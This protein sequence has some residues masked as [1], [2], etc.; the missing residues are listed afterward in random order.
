MSSNASAGLA[1]LLLHVEAALLALNQFATETNDDVRRPLF[2][3]RNRYV[4]L[5]TSVIKAPFSSYGGPYSIDYLCSFNFASHSLFDRMQSNLSTTLDGLDDEDDDGTNDHR[6]RQGKVAVS[7]P[8]AYQLSDD[9][10]QTLNRII[11]TVNMLMFRIFSRVK[12]WDDAS[13]CRDAM[14]VLMELLG[15]G[16]KASVPL[17][18]LIQEKW[19][20]SESV[21]SYSHTL[22]SFIDLIKTRGK[23][24][25]YLQ[26]LV[27]LCSANGHAI[28]KIQEKLCELLFDTED[29]AA[30][31]IPTQPA[32]RG[33]EISIPAK[34]S[35]VRL[36]NLDVFYNEY[37]DSKRHT[38]LAPYYYGLLQLYCA[39]CMDRNY[40][41]IQRL[42]AIFPRANLLQTVQDAGLSRSMRAVLLNLL[43]VL[44]VDCEPQTV[45]PS[46][47]YTR[48]WKNAVV[49]VP[50]TALH[51]ADATFFGDL[52]IELLR[53]FKKHHGVIV[54]AEYPQNE[55][56]LAMVRTT[57]KLVAFGMFSSDLRHLV[58]LLVDL[59]D[60]R[61]DLVE[62]HRPTASTTPPE[63]S[64]PFFENSV[65]RQKHPAYR[66]YSV[67]D[68]E[69]QPMLPVQEPLSSRDV[70]T[71][72][73]GWQ[74][75]YT[76][77]KKEL[78]RFSA[79][80]AKSSSS[81]LRRLPDSKYTMSEWN[82][83]VMDIKE[84]I[85]T[86]LLCIDTFRLD[87]Q[88]S[89][90]LYTLHSTSKRSSTSPLTSSLWGSSGKRGT[91]LTSAMQN[92]SLE[93][94][95]SLHVLAGRRL[96]TVLLQALMYE[97][98]PLVS[99]ALELYMQ[100]FNQHDQL[101]K[102]LSSTLVIADD[103]TVQ[104]YAR[105]QAHVNDLRRLAETTE[106]WMDLTSDADF[107]TA[108]KACA[109]LRAILDAFNS[110][111][112]HR[113]V[114]HRI[115][116]N[117]QAIDH[118][119]AMVSA[120][121][122]FFQALFPSK[123][124]R[125]ASGC[126]PTQRYGSSMNVPETVLEEKQRNTLYAVYSH[127]TE[128]L[129]HICQHP[130][131]ASLMDTH[132]DTLLEFAEA[133][134]AA[135]DALCGLYLGGRT[136]A[137]PKT[138]V[139]WFVRW[140]VAYKPEGEARYLEFLR[141]L[142][143]RPRDRATILQQL[144]QY[145]SIYNDMSSGRHVKY[146]AAVLNLLAAC[147]PTAEAKDACRVEFLSLDQW[148]AVLEGGLATHEWALGLAC[149]RYFKDVILAQDDVF[150]G[151][152]ASLHL[153]ILQRV[154]ELTAKC[155]RLDL[156]ALQQV[157]LQLAAPT[158]TRYTL[159][160]IMLVLV[161]ALDA[162]LPR[163]MGI[164]KPSADEWRE[165]LAGWYIWLFGA[166]VPTDARSKDEL[167]SCLQYIEVL[168]AT[169]FLG[170][171]WCDVSERSER[172]RLDAGLG[173]LRSNAPFVLDLDSTAF[174]DLLVE[175][176]AYH[177][178]LKQ[179]P[180]PVT[181]AAA[182]PRRLS[183]SH[184]PWAPALHDIVTATDVSEKLP[185]LNIA[186]LEAK[187]SWVR[188]IQAKYGWELEMTDGV[189]HG[190]ALGSK[191]SAYGMPRGSDGADEDSAIVQDF[192][193]YLRSHRRIKITVRDELSHMMRDIVSVQVQLKV[194]HQTNPML[195]LIALTFDDIVA[196]L[197]CHFK[198]LK[199]PTHIKM[200]LTLLEVFIQM[201]TSVDTSEHRN[202]MQVKL[203]TLGA[204]ELVVDLVSST[205][206]QIVLDKSIE[207]GIALLNGMNAKVQE[208][209]YA[210]WIESTNAAFFQ[211]LQ[212]RLEAAM[213]HDNTAREL[214]LTPRRPKSPLKA[215]SHEGMS[216]YEAIT[217]L[218]RF[219][220]L[221]C[222]GHY[223]DT[224]RYLIAQRTSSHNLVSTTVAYLMDVSG[225]LSA[226]T[227]AVHKQVFDT[228]T[229]CCQ[230]PCHE[231]QETVAT[232]A[233]VSTVNELMLFSS[234]S[235][236]RL[237][238]ASLVLFRDLKAS[239]VIALSSLL[240]GRHDRQIHDRL[241]QELNFDALKDN[242]VDAYHYF[243][244]RYSRC[245]HDAYLGMGFNLHILMQQLIEHQP[246][247]AE[248]LQ[249]RKVIK[250]K[251]VKDMSYEKAYRFFHKRCARVEIVWPIVGGSDAVPPLI[252]VHFPIHPIC[253]CVTDATRQQLLQDISRDANKLYD[254]YVKTHLVLEEMQHQCTLRQNHLKAVLSKN[255]SQIKLLTFVWSLLLNFI[256]LTNYAL[257]TVWYFMG[258]IHVLLTVVLLFMY[259]TNSVPLLLQRRATQH[260]YEDAP[261]LRVDDKKTLQDVE[262]LVRCVGSDIKVQPLSRLETVYVILTDGRLLYRGLLVCVAIAGVLIEP[263]FFSFH[264]VDFINRSQELRDVLRAVVVPG[265]TLLH[266]VVFYLLLV[267]VF[268]VIAYTYFPG[269]FKVDAST[270]GCETV[271]ECFLT[272][273]DQGFKNNGGLGA[274][275]PSHRR[276]SDSLG[277]I[278]FFYDLAYNIVLIIV[279]INLTFGVIIDTFASLRTSHKEQLDENRDRC[280]VCSIDGYTFNRLTR[281]GFEH[282]TTT[283]HNVWHYIYLFAH[284]RKKPF[285]EY[286]GVE[287]YLALKMAR[288]DVSF[289]PSHRALSLEKLATPTPT[290]SHDSM[291]DALLR[292]EAQLARL[293]QAHATLDAKCDA[294][295]RR[296][297]EW[298]T[299][300]VSPKTHPTPATTIF[301]PETDQ[302]DTPCSHVG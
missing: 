42:R 167:H 110:K 180:K 86:T 15:H 230:G 248:A 214:P 65:Q 176:Q 60:S 39:L 78:H 153:R 136:D 139:A 117:I 268:A 203:D 277:Y 116:R 264:L 101:I 16:F 247:I 58:P 206:D 96:D 185:S 105:L 18:F 129:G 269:D 72:R 207:L 184:V 144:Q 31:L 91:P 187:T 30:L 195:P 221:L 128:F 111:E 231:A 242:V 89:S 20:V 281:R 291:H 118:V 38:T 24:I 188:K 6:G 9:S 27:V 81:S 156:L 92:D 67:H 108:S 280:F 293:L 12:T 266:I 173:G 218:L 1:A 189:A 14:P 278:R 113:A 228:I 97:H 64:V 17:S 300:P 196:K 124:P 182:S 302:S 217:R 13:A 261:S 142:A 127:C 223:L 259:W 25:R 253:V 237:S 62:A 79:L 40:V 222:E 271:W 244:H 47:R 52:K 257:V 54:I 252:A 216:K 35:G 160:A 7:L 115:L 233:F 119:V 272:T 147:A 165:W 201:I 33:F 84:S 260:A 282:H 34:P 168:W 267:Y 102:A 73:S 51:G 107:S 95:Y 22:R 205:E 186:S 155:I 148:L 140:A 179:H 299:K 53:Y 236:Q 285:T 301:F 193:L 66:Q 181:A 80:S 43:V 135:Q 161:P 21:A 149:L 46:P 158:A 246:S 26:F 150:D 75:A 61:T 134:P 138:V 279:L 297:D 98:P 57:Q 44:H 90:V 37:Y 29:S 141:S 143:T 202:A 224:Q 172:P 126:G 295:A 4:E 83:V 215:P 183:A 77:A 100:Q 87:Y 131:N 258:C 114:I 8:A 162:Y 251:S 199:Y 3:R 175:V 45:L 192:V 283:E 296:L 71:S 120:G 250:H 125:G 133:L 262:R 121:S 197:V 286:N 263:L 178:Y 265:K 93:C 287:L 255:A 212:S 123:L 200:S 163:I 213:T 23:S 209:F 49:E 235:A 177:A 157:D 256:V 68:T 48:I 194:E 227:L 191:S 5:L 59:L 55:L 164:V 190:H 169:E 211:R 41:C 234:K 137:T 289:F 85:C 82:K 146:T 273:L 166:W 70:Q 290:P 32:S 210:I 19:H 151:V 225:A 88:L 239:I 240:E 104:M 288:G 36:V 76:K 74:A 243:E 103:A 204:T 292:V 208:H 130:E 154:S 226:E 249:P 241:I 109:A 275:L 10:M 145:P 99:K 198:M 63:Y 170:D 11:C 270:N 254:F 122:H 294:T 232:Y 245:S 69:V 229:E 94:I 28:A 106:V 276:G 219:L 174:A 50:S 112:S 220:Q 171:L 159:D 132:A 152:P 238:D 2:L 56:T 274:Y 298:M 284:I